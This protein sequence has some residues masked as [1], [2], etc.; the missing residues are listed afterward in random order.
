[1]DVIIVFTSVRSLAAGKAISILQ[2]IQSLI[3]CSTRKTKSDYGVDPQQS[4]T[5]G[6]VIWDM[7]YLSLS[8]L[9]PLTIQ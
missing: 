2:P 7:N 5:C 6:V 4:Q 1:V 9:W 3:N 8:S